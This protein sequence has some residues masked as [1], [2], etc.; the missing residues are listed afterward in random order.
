[1]PVGCGSWMLRG[2]STSRLARRRTGRISDHVS[3]CFR[4][5][6]RVQRGRA[7]RAPSLSRPAWLCPCSSAL[8]LVPR[9]DRTAG[10][11]SSKLNAPLAAKWQSARR[12]RVGRKRGGETSGAANL[13]VRCW[14]TSPLQ[15]ALRRRRRSSDRSAQAG[16]RIRRCSE[17]AKGMCARYD[18]ALLRGGCAA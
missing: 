14:P 5:R 18:R 15:E 17:R 8:S 4:P 7:P 3:G 6:C 11:H 9:C 13:S 16:H 1:M 10:R 2:Q 12:A